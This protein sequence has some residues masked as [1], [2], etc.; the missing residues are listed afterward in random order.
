[1]DLLV[2]IVFLLRSSA[3]TVFAAL[4]I[5]AAGVNLTAGA[6]LNVLILGVAGLMFISRPRPPVLSSVWL[7]FVCFAGL[8][9]VW[10]PQKGDAV[11]QLLVLL[12]YMAMFAIPLMV[13]ETTRMNATL[14]KAII[15]SSIVPCV[16][17]FLQFAFFLD[18]TGRVKS[19]FLHANVF[20]FYL[21]VIAGLILFLL[22][23]TTVEFKPAIR[24]YMFVYLMVVGAALALTQ[25]RAAWIGMFVILVVQAIF[26]NRRLLF[27][28]L[29]LPLLLFVPQVADRLADLGQG[30]EYRGEFKSQG[31]SVNS[32]TWRKVMWQSAVDDLG[33]AFLHGKGL[34]SFGPNSL[35]FFPIVDLQHQYSAK[36][37]GAHNVYVQ[38]LYETGLIGLLCYLSIFVRLLARTWRYLRLD[39]KGA[40]TSMS[41]VSAY[42][43]ESFSDN[44]FD[45]GSLNLYFWG[46]LGII[47]S[48]WELR[49]PTSAARS[50]PS[51]ETAPILSAAK[52]QPSYS[53]N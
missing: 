4:T 35:L 52:R 21:T 12:T 23:S 3:D 26:I 6:L 33:G 34:A 36:G 25:S 10:A 29:L 32:F 22:S 28:L 1:M 43:L 13:R 11:R 14:L 48:Y 20:G 19:L 18:T 7:P 9:I 40:L 30:T 8:S 16:V 2:S 27:V 47:F 24:K 50:R 31:D 53:P 39:R 44:M 45:Y 15:Y 5:E 41:I 46:T 17:G 42:A 51:T 38:T 49:S 37:V